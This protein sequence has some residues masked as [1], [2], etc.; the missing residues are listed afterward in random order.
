MSFL[1]VQAQNFSLSGAGAI[2]G[3]TSITLKSFAQIDGTLLT[4]TD[5][6]AVGY[7]TMEPGNGTLEEQVS[8]T[9]VVQN[10]N[11]TATLSGIKTVLDVSPY[12]ET[13]GLA[14]THAGSTT[15]VLSNTAG[16]YHQFPAKDNDETITGQWT[17]NTFPI[18]P[19]NS[20]ASTTVKGVTKVSVAPAAAAN[21]IA[22]GTNDPRLQMP[23]YA[24]TSVGT[25]A[26]A[27]TLTSAAVPVAYNTGDSYTFKADVA[28]TGAAT[29]NVN[30]LGAKSIVKNGSTVLSTN[31]IL[32]GQIVQVEYDG[33]NFQMIS[34]VSP[35]TT[36][37][38]ASMVYNSGS[39]T[40]NLADATA[41]TQN[42][43]HGL[44]VAPSKVRLKYALYGT[45]TLNTSDGSWMN[46]KYTTT[47]TVMFEDTSNGL[48]EAVTT[49][50]IKLL[51]GGSTSAFQTATVAVDATNIT[52]TWTKTSTPTGTI[53]F[54]WEAEGQTTTT[55]V[56]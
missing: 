10:A 50:V 40:K 22:V 46:A 31:N 2:A 49:Y 12:T 56:V 5:F 38:V 14:Q 51:P 55:V 16:F 28:N 8:F 4:M 54:L 19:S 52:L 9:G 35:L 37:V 18:T 23:Y 20:D 36:T 21:P 6:G 25:D 24:A 53:T 7:L 3:A 47:S 34:P 42:I 30:T 48:G 15:V 27:I 45:D 32:A 29:L 41:A 17:F 13:S 1:P 39:D 11:G 26:Y 33:T 44:G 43:A